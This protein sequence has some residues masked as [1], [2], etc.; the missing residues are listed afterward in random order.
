MSIQEFLK[1]YKPEKV[2]DSFGPFKGNY[3]CVVNHARIEE[4]SGEREEWRGVD[5]FRYELEVAE[6]QPNAGRRLWKSVALNNEERVRKLAN[7]F[8]TIGLEFKDRE[9]LLECAERFVEMTLEVRAWYFT[10]QDADEPVQ[11]HLIKGV[12]KEQGVRKESEV[13]F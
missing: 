4:Y 8:F 1:D 12:A 10:P 7:I 11:M 2:T 5:F 13:P 6:G 3:K 9:E